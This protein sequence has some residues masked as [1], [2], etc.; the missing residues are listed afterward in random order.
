MVTAKIKRDDHN[1]NTSSSPSPS[2]EDRRLL[3]RGSFSSDDDDG[4]NNDNDNDDKPVNPAPKKSSD[5][6]RTPH[7]VRFNLPPTDASS[8]GAENTLESDTPSS[9][10][11]PLLL[12]DIEAPSIHLATTPWPRD[13]LHEYAERERQR[14]RSTL[15]SAFMN[16]AN[17]IIGA[18]IIGQPYAVQQAGLV[19]F[20]VLLVALTLLIDWT[21][22]LIVVNSKLSGRNSFQGTMEHCFGHAGLLAISLAQWAFAFGGMIAFCVIV[23]DSIPAVLRAVWP[24]LEDVPVLGLL[25]GRRVAIVVFVMGVSWPL[26][27]YRDISKVRSLCWAFLYV[28]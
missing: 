2:H 19:A 5:S 10:S 21:I 12:T 7:R 18:G 25:A 23:G 9:S 3:S 14:P 17:S 4:D 1:V 13:D 20:S 15:R 6:P 28:C 27:L 24:G 16:M 26:S 22:R 11:A 8:P